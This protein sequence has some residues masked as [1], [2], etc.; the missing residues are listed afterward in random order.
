MPDESCASSSNRVY[1]A[2]LD[3]E[4]GTYGE[5]HELEG[6]DCIRIEED[7]PRRTLLTRWRELYR[8]ATGRFDVEA[9][10]G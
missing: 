4:T 8:Y 2:L 7:R 6:I 10:V 5:M 1:Y 3:E 9:W